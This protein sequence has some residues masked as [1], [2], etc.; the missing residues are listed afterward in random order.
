MGKMK[1]LSN[2]MRWP[3][4]ALVVWGL[5]WVFYTMMLSQGAS[6]MAAMLL[7]SLAALTASAVA[8]IRGV[9]KARL[10]ALALGFPVSLWLSGTA[11]LPAWVWLLPLALALLIYPVHAW[12]DAPVFPTPL[13]ALKDLPPCAPLPPQAL[14]LDA[15]CGAGDGL[16][17]LRLAYP[18]ARWVGIEFSWPLRFVAQL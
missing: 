9:S 12:R 5:A 6:P 1:Q 13:H 3:I 11:S 16:K 7:A 10:V 14:I 4:S 15:G 8:W 2:L 18:Q 17:A